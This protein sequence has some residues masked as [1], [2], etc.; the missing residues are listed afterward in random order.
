MLAL[1]K[2]ASE[3]YWMGVNVHCGLTGAQFPD[4]AS[5]LQEIE[6]DFYL[7]HLLPAPCWRQEQIRESGSVVTLLVA[8]SVKLLS[9]PV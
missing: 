4:K 1:A 6:L 8:V 3:P 7:D 2:E 9:H 5:E